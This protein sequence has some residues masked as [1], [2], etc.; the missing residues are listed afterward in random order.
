[1]TGFG[2]GLAANSDWQVTVE[3]QSVNRKQL[4]VVFQAPREL[5]VL[6]PRVRKRVQEVVS[7]GRIQLSVN[8][9]RGTDAV[10][11]MTVDTGLARA[12]SQAVEEL[13]KA[14]GRSLQPTVAD[15]L[16][17][18]G[19]I[20]QSTAAVDVDS[21]WPCLEQALEIALRAHKEMRSSEGEHLAQDVNARLKL[22]RGVVA[23]MALLAPA[24]LVKMRESLFNRLRESGIEL[25]LSDGR[26]LSE[27]ALYADRCDISEEL[28]RLGSH[29]EKFGSYLASTDS[30]GRSLDFLCQEIF[31]EFNT[32]GSK[33]NDAR[34]AQMVVEAKTELEKIREQVQNIE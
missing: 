34:I 14:T 1:M 9:E 19:V 17:Q 21:I 20:R 22:L 33:A 11:A 30:T 7:R 15:Y 8:I 16:K 6:E 31:R 10:V 2:R 29:F 25:D 32:V 23:E 18:P 27:L 12:L 4:D 13:G 28:T 26:L 5:A 3:I 24:R